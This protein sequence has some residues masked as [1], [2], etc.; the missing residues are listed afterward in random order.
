MTA[1]AWVVALWG[2]LLLTA[3]LGFVAW[4]RWQASRERVRLGR[5]RIEMGEAFLG[6]ALDEDS[7]PLTDAQEAYREETARRKRAFERRQV[8]E[9]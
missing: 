8:F 1:L 4:L 5:R 2:L 6:S 9:R 7:E 3:W